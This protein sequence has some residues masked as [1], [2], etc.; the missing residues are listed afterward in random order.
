MPL[1]NVYTVHKFGHTIIIPFRH[2]KKK[3]RST[4]VLLKANCVEYK[5]LVLFCK[6][7]FA[8]Q[9]RIRQDLEVSDTFP[10]FIEAMITGSLWVLWVHMAQYK[11]CVKIV[12]KKKTRWVVAFLIRQ[13]KVESENI[14]H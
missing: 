10:M 11:N 12:F 2:F 8:S 3:I 7:S 5:I 14:P 1:I 13:S 6:G 9:N 4:C